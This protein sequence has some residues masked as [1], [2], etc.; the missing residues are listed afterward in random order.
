MG[1]IGSQACESCWGEREHPLAA[2]AAAAAEDRWVCCSI[3]E[4]NA[5]V[6]GQTLA[7]WPTGGSHNPHPPFTYMCICTR[8]AFAY[9]VY[10]K[11]AWKMSMLV[12][13][14]QDWSL[15]VEHLARDL[16][17][18]SLAV[19]VSSLRIESS[20]SLLPLQPA[21]LRSAPHKPQRTMLSHSLN[22]GRPIHAQGEDFQSYF[23]R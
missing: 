2:A 21:S 16:I 7:E 9:H 23:S 22:W 20:C 6:T 18:V 5:K 11:H 15:L 12:M 8:R 10:A 17:T 13:C 19:L 3:T 14:S 4:G 1:S